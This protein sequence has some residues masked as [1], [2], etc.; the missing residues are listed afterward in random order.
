MTRGARGPGWSE[1]IRPRREGPG[2]SR[3]PRL[4]PLDH[5]YHLLEA[6]PGDPGVAWLSSHR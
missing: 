2:R 1:G 4:C 3:P 5:V 6:A